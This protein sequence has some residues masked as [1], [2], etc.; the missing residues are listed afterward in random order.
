MMVATAE[1]ASVPKVITPRPFPSIT[2]VGAA[3]VVVLVLVVEVLMLVVVDEVVVGVVVDVVVVGCVV[4]VVVVVEVV[5]SV[6][7]TGSSPVPPNDAITTAAKM[8]VV[9]MAKVS[10]IRFW[11]EFMST[12]DC[13]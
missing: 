8:S 13:G 12:G 7:V 6:A 2:S 9:T 10:T 11:V 1:S 3:V 5:V 4:V